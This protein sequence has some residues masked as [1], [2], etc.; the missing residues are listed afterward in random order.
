MKKFFAL[1]LVFALALSFCGCGSS[2]DK[3]ALSNFSATDLDGNAVNESIFSDYEL[4]MVNVWATYCGPCINEMPDLGE[5]AEEYED[6]GVQI[7]GLVLDI[8]NA[9]D[10]SQISLANEIVNQTG[11]YYTHIVPSSDLE[12]FIGE[13]TA[14]PTTYFVDNDGNLVGNPYVGSKSKSQW[15]SIIAETLEEVQK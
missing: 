7:I 6:K 13:I 4:T 8:S 11:A 14:V 9:N 5:L 15:K 3:G 12:D 10:K 2:S 1:I